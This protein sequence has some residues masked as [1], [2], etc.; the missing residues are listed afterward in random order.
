MYVTTKALPPVEEDRNVPPSNAP[1]S[2]VK[3]HHAAG[4]LHPYKTTPPYLYRIFMP[5]AGPAAIAVS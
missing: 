2:E 4:D 5:D 3:H 1:Q